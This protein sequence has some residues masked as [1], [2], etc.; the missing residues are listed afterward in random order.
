MQR[1]LIV[2]D[3]PLYLEGMM[4]ALR[5]RLDE[6][7]VRGVGSAEA[8][9]EVL[10]G[11]PD[12]DLVLLDLRLPGMD[13][14]MALS[15]LA[16]RFP[17]VSCMVISGEEDPR[18]VRRAFDAGASGFL[19]KSLSIVE[20]SDAIRRVLAGH[21]YVPEL[22]ALPAARGPQG[23]SVDG[24][25]LRQLEALRLLGEGRSNKEIARMLQITERTARAHVAAILDV[26]GAE[27]RT[28]AVLA[29]QRLGLLKV[30]SD[31]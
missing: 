23:R 25:T 15:T 13:G 5:T 14:F 24:L 22:A 31:P 30:G 28:Q 21:V 11:D 18:L 10:A 16:A 29:A 6:V 2:D 7:E 17:T 8:C 12:I 1:I 19:P 20:A 9:L 26:L 4:G 3:H 27:N